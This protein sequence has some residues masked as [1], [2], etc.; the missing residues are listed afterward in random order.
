MMWVLI[1]APTAKG[2]SQMRNVVASLF[3]SLD[4]EVGAPDQWQFDGFDGDMMTELV[5]QISNLDTVLLGRVTY[6]EWSAYW[7]TATDEPFASFINNVP[8]VVVSTTL[9]EVSWGNLGKVSLMQGSLAETIA[10][11]KQQ[12][13]K[14][15]GVSGSVTLVQSLLENDL[16]DML[17]LQVHP[18]IAGKGKFLFKENSALKR[19]ALVENKTAGSGVVMLTYQVRR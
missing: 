8:K 3:I 18:V 6:E 7:P 14:N 17:Y 10:Q 4:G 1:G 9:R 15:I 11:L 5:A 12:P 19:L 13:G 2:K 16:L